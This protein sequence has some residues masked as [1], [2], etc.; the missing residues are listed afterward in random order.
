MYKN[1]Y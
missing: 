1:R